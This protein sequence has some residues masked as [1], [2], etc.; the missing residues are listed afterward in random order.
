MNPSSL[1]KF[2]F[3]RYTATALLGGLMLLNTAT[4]HASVLYSCPGGAGDDFNSRGFYMPS[5]PGITLD[6]ATLKLLGYSP[7]TYQV[8]LTVR[9]NTYNSHFGDNLRKIFR[10]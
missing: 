6:S 9:S 4:S 1:I 2:T 8:S 3:A 7:G 10:R 5:Y